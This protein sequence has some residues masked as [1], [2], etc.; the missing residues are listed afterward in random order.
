M[1][2]TTRMRRKKKLS[3]R[4]LSCKVNYNMLNK[5][6]NIPTPYANILI[7]ET[8]VVLYGLRPVVVGTKRKPL[9][10]FPNVKIVTKMRNTHGYFAFV[11]WCLTH[12]RNNEMGILP[13]AEL[14]TTRYYFTK[15]QSKVECPIFVGILI[16]K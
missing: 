2:Q 15:V 12:R 1:P 16:F 10:V 14:V 6:R 4:M 8:A 7:V 13:C 3:A 5:S 9:A 11:I